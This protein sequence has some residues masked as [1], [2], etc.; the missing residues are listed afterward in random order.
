MQQR[1]A[2]AVALCQEV[3]VAVDACPHVDELLDE[4]EIL[5]EG[6]EHEQAGLPELRLLAGGLGGRAAQQLHA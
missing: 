5:P 2:V 6:R 3:A 4:G 1:V